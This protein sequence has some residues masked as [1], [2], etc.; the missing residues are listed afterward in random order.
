MQII[1]IKHV[2]VDKHVIT[3]IFHGRLLKK[4]AFET[5]THFIVNHLYPIITIYYTRLTYL[6]LRYLLTHKKTQNPE[7]HI[8][9]KLFPIRNTF[10]CSI[11]LKMLIKYFKVDIV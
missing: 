11:I 3:E 1:P 2:T 8:K 7:K 10:S 5:T 6:L 9:L 4:S